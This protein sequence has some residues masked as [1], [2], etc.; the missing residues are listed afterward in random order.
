MLAATRISRRDAAWH[1]A[2]ILL[3]QHQ[4]AVL[5]RQIG[6]HARPKV[7]W[8][9]GLWALVLGLIPR[10]RHVRMRLIVTPGT[11]LR[12]RRDLQ[13]RRWARKHRPK[14]QPR[15]HR[16]VRALALRMARENDAWGYRRIAGELA[17]LGSRSR[18][19]P[20]GRS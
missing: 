20:C 8:T 19:R 9:D 15:T 16:N 6:E 1:T 10:A 18:R 17:G 13:R 5:Q 2:E 14:G 3:L 7:S 11:I 12:W 4:F